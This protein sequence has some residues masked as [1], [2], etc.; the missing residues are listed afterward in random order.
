MIRPLFSIIPLLGFMAFTSSSIA[1]WVSLVFKETLGLITIVSI[2][3]N[4]SILGE[5]VSKEV[6]AFTID[7]ML[8]KLTI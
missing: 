6:A 1:A 4:K 3:S 8:S 7:S 5:M 2:F